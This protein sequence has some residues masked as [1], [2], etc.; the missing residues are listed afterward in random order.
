MDG[1]ALRSEEEGLGERALCPRVMARNK[2]ISSACRRPSHFLFEW[3]RTRRSA[4]EQRS[5]PE[6]RRAGC[7]ESRK[8]N[9]RE[10]TPPMARPPPIHGLRV[11][12][13]VTG[14]SDDTSLYRRKTGPHP[15]GPSCGLSST[16]PPRHRDPGRAARSC[17]QKQNAG[18]SPPSGRRAYF[19]FQGNKSYQLHFAQY[20]RRHVRDCPPKKDGQSLVCTKG[21][22]A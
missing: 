20:A 16:H 21:F 10:R 9:P 22:L 3:P 12:G 18:V 6:G 13:R 14:F 4:C 5:W 2:A 17:A 11:R 8:S 1:P 15:C 19:T 7:P